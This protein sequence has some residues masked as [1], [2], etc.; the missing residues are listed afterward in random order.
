MLWRVWLSQSKEFKRLNL[1]FPTFQPYLFVLKTEIQRNPDRF[2]NLFK[3]V[4]ATITSRSISAAS[5]NCR[6]GRNRKAV[7]QVN[8][9]VVELVSPWSIHWRSAKH[10]QPHVDY[11]CESAAKAI[12]AMTRVMSSISAI[13]SAM[14]RFLA[15]VSTQVPLRFCLGSWPGICRRWTAHTGWWLW[16]KTVRTGPYPRK[17]SASLLVWFPNEY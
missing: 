7:Q 10:Q 15:S 9:S 5:R 4:S 2:K 13:S 6:F 3:S 14:R 8:I 17:R 1:P 12:I 16:V 11:A